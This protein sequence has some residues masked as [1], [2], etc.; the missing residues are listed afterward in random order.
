MDVPDRPGDFDG[1]EDSRQHQGYDCPSLLQRKNFR[2]GKNKRT[3]QF[4]IYIYIPAFIDLLLLLVGNDHALAHRRFFWVIVDS[5]CFD[6]CPIAHCW[7]STDQSFSYI[8]TG[9]GHD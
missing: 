3:T 7:P 5:T 6:S 4:C 8:Q 9:V 1:L 2:K